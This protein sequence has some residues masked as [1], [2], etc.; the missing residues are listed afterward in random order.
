LKFNRFFGKQ[1][2]RLRVGKDY[3][4]TVSQSIQTVSLVV[5]ALGIIGENITLITYGVLLLIG[6]GVFWGV[7]YVTQKTQIR[8]HDQE[9]IMRQNIRG[10]KIVNRIVYGKVIIPMFIKALE[11]PKRVLED[12]EF[13]I[14]WIEEYSKTKNLVD[15]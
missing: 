5:I 1:L 6:L 11:D 7:G 2:A 13:L 14:T 10:S 4:A 12:P 15:D 8:D 3:S 9:I